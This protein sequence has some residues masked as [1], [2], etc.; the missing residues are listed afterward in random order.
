MQTVEFKFKL[1]DKLETPF[2]ELAIIQG[3]FF[4]DS[5]NQYLCRT[6]TGDV[7]MKESELNALP[8]NP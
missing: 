6:K 3:L 8:T 4:D 5:G 1:N 7:W 2:N